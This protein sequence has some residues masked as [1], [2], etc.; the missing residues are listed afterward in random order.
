MGVGLIEAFALI[1]RYG[2]EVL[3]NEEIIFSARAKKKK[4]CRTVSSSI[5][6]EER[7]QVIELGKRVK[8]W[9]DENR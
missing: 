9:K 5:T 1:D 3:S 8:R 6:T 4:G 7:M 2:R